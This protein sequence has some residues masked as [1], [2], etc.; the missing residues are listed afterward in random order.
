MILDRYTTFRELIDT[1]N[2]M[3]PDSVAEQSHAE[4]RHIGIHLSHAYFPISINEQEFN[5][6]HDVIISNNLKNGFELA[7]GTGISTI[8]NSNKTCRIPLNKKREQ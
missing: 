2:S 3:L 1:I 7:T 6:M 5:Y 8:L 4:G